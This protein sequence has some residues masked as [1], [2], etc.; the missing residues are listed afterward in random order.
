MDLKVY[1]WSELLTFDRLLTLIPRLGTREMGLNLAITPEKA[2]KVNRV[3]RECDNNDVEL[4]FWP[5]LSKEKGYWIN[6]WNINLQEKWFG[7]LLEHF[8]TISSYLLDL[9]RPINFKG[10]KGNIQNAKLK[11]IIPDGLV[12]RKL[13]DLVNKIHDH[14]KKVVSTSYGGIPLGMNPRPSNA[15]WYSYMVY[16][17]FVNRVANKDTREN[18]IFHCANKIREE[19]GQEKAAIDLGLTY[20]GIINKGLIDFLGYLSMKELTSQIGICKYAKVNRVHVFSIDSMTK[21]LNQW[22]DAIESATPKTPPLLMSG[23]KGFMYRAYRKIL[24]SKDLNAF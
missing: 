6:R 5:L 14:G 22:F 24:F 9:E 4:N 23:K 12:R 10:I 16:T 11:K 17:S 2:R 15:D 19:H 8:P 18:I 7:F 20:H 1:F 13:E 21:N 3:V